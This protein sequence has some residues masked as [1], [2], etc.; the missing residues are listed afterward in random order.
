MILLHYIFTILPLLAVATTSPK[1]GLVY[2][3][4]NKNSINDISAWTSNTDLTWYY[5]YA[6]SPVSQLSGSSLQFVPMLWGTPASG[7]D[8]QFLNTVTA[9]QKSEN[10]THVLGFNEPDLGKSVGGSNM[11]PSDAS[12]IW[13]KQLEPLRRL[14]I[15]VGAPAVSGSPTG[16]A[17][18]KQWI[19]ACK[20]KCNPDFLPVHWYGDFEGLASWIGNMSSTYPEL[21]IWVTEFALPNAGLADTQAFFNQS[22]SLLDGWA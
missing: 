5:N 8:T 12:T 19:A 21:E 10:I 4:N 3:G 2:V 7:Q 15:K 16:Y 18:L 6:S 14:G 11:A 20:G 17:W 13:Q 22:V 1:R 9:Q